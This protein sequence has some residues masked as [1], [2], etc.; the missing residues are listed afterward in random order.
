MNPLSDCYNRPSWT[1]AIVPLA[2]ISF[3]I[4][5][6][7]WIM[8]QQMTPRG[9][10]L[11]WF[12]SLVYAV[13][14]GMPLHLF[15]PPVIGVTEHL[16]K[17]VRWLCRGGFILG[18]TVA[19]SVVAALVP[20]LLMGVSYWVNLKWS[21]LLSLFITLIATPMFYG[22]E[23][24]QGRLRRNELERARALKLAT[25]AR[26]ASLESRIH[27]HF[28]FNTINSVSSLIHDD[29]DRAERLLT[30]MANL[31]RF[32]LDSSHVGVVPLEKELKIVRE[33]LE[34]EKAR[35]N[36]RLQYDLNVPPE[37]AQSPVPPLSL[38][39]LVENSIKYAVA[40]RREGG[41]ISV[42][43]SAEGKTISL[44]VTD[45]GPGFS[46][47][48]VLAGHGI[49]NLQERLYALYGDGASLEIGTGTSGGNVR[50]VIPAKA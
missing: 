38:Q 14:I 45:D 20:Y 1:R 23:E 41:T 42:A 3:A 30:Q 5:L 21:L 35:F 43:A 9:F 29:P 37:L 18:V 19:G 28:L 32:S 25:E 2:A 11:Q 49:H 4:P 12:F 47:S 13:C 26:L 24:L 16:G 40:P 39:T 6:L 10:L 36:G 48:D 34:I 31:L 8:T 44:D 15:I 46:S 17:R 7:Q 22:Y 27:P 33:Y 50:M